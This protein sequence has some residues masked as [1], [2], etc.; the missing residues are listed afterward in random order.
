M[1]SLS[2]SFE[3]MQDDAGWKAKLKLP[4]QDLRIK[5]SVSALIYFS[6]N[7]LLIIYYY[8]GCDIYQ[9]E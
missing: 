2:R 5:T 6:K 7:N 8:V 9:R 1:F 4:P 3:G